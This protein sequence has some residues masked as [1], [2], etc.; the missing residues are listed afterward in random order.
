MYT[1][2]SNIKNTPT[3]NKHLFLLAELFYN[4]L[5]QNRFS[6]LVLTGKRL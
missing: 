2:L 4:I 3:N 5:N 1:F 6:F